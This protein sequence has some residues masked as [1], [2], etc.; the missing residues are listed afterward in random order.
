MTRAG[1]MAVL[2]VSLALLEAACLE[3]KP[4]TSD[5]LMCTTKDDCA[6]GE[7]C[8]DGRCYGRPPSL[9]FAAELHPP[10]SRTDLAK[11]ELPVLAIADD[12]LLTNVAFGRTAGLSGRVALAANP[13]GSV[14]AKLELRRASRIPGGPEYVVAVDARP[15]ADPLAPSFF[16]RLPP[17]QPG[18]SYQLT[19]YPD[20][21]AIASPAEGFPSPAELAPPVRERIVIAEGMVDEVFLLGDPDGQK[22]IQGRVVDAVRLGVPGMIVRAYGSYV[23]GQPR[24]LASSLGRTDASGAFLVWV[25]TS[26]ADVFDLVVTPVDGQSR[27]TITRRNVLV[28]DPAGQ[29]VVPAN[30]GELVLPSYPN[31]VE[32]TIPV[33]GRSSAGGLEPVVGAKI[34][35]RTTIGGGP[36]DASFA[37]TGTAGVNGEARLDVIPAGAD[38]N[39]IYDVDVVPPPG[40]EQ[41]GLWHQTIE[42]GPLG[43]TLAPMVLPARGLVT[44]RILDADG[45]AVPG[46]LI[47]ARPSLAFDLG[48]DPGE[49]ATARALEWP[50]TG[51]GTDGSFAIFLDGAVL[52]HDTTYNLEVEPPAGSPIPHWSFDR[53]SF[54]KD[55]L[56]G[57]NPDAQ[58]QAVD[59][60]ERRLPAGS[61]VRGQV[62]DEVGNPVPDAE[63]RIYLLEDSAACGSW[64]GPECIPP[65]RL[66][67]LAES[68]ADGTL[69]LVLPSP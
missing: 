8:V 47:R 31:P 6:P 65:A 32:V 39:R 14:A 50:M 35:V 33:A 3:V 11:T 40:S 57:G 69:Q 9:K 26:W 18:E 46:L 30:I 41:A 17:C 52:G 62:V 60:G 34:T 7:G 10:S 44:G 24:E 15:T 29:F 1:G 19:I 2:A 58:P 53:V 37:T 45:D 12:G 28:E 20:D 51:V 42:V 59:L 61:F 21:G 23:D 16:V 64:A 13:T 54:P 36:D 5:G 56:P 43:G 67:S 22:Q 55:T 27:P 68:Q 63:L 48:L 49:I 38:G 4:P 25:P 66:N